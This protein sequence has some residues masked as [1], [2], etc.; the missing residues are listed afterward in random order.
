MIKGYK[1]RVAFFIERWIDG[2]TAHG[3]VDRGWGD[4]Y[5]P[6]KGLRLLKGDGSTFD[7]PELHLEPVRAEAARMRAQALA[8]AGNWYYIVSQ[9]VDPDSFGRILCSIELLD[10][11]DLATTLATEGHSK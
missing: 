8:P 6:P 10:S 3:T 4:R 2:D 1:P 7:A 5:T 9:R 11:T